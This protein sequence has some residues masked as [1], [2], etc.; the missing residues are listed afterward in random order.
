[1]SIW[2]P[3]RSPDHPSEVV[4]VAQAVLVEVQVG[5]VRLRAIV[6]DVFVVVGVHHEQGR[7][8]TQRVAERRL[9]EVGVSTVLHV[10][11]ASPPNWRVLYGPAGP[12]HE[13]SVVAR[14]VDREFA[15]AVKVR[16]QPLPVG[17]N[18]VDLVEGSTANRAFGSRN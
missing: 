8:R 10:V 12:G 14:H 16:R 2:D 15:Q 9:S 5:R 11:V 18:V 4:G 3:Y 6:A 1:V 13:R 17:L 7:H